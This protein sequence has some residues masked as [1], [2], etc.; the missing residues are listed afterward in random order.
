MI[1]KYVVIPASIAAL[2]IPTLVAFAD[3]GPK[4]SQT[5]PPAPPPQ[6]DGRNAPAGFPAHQD[7][8]YGMASDTPG[9][10]HIMGSSTEM[11]LGT[12]TDMHGRSRMPGMHGE[13]RGLLMHF[14]TTTPPGFRH[15]E[16]T[17]TDREA[18]STE[19][20]GKGNDKEGMQ[21]QG[22]ISAFLNWFRGSHLSTTTPPVPA[23]ATSTATGTP[24]QQAPTPSE[25]GLIQQLLGFLRSFGK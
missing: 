12:S 20:R 21:S 1:K 9:M 8:P 23:S 17:S 24:P 4:G 15:R 18:T 6:N 19:N 14:G 2:L 13:K 10:M 22:I 3:D 5:F 11:R 25:Q 16:A 7:E